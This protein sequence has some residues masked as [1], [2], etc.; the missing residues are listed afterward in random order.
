MEPDPNSLTYKRILNNYL[1]LETI[2][3]EEL[4]SEEKWD[5]DVSSDTELEHN[6]DKLSK[7]ANR[8]TNADPEKDSRLI[9]HPDVGQCHG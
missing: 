2:R 7:D 4:I 5:V 6:R 8:R 9:T 3:W 1:D